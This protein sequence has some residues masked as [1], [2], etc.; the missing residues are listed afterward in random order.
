MGT[1]GKGKNVIS[2][3]RVKSNTGLKEKKELSRNERRSLGKIRASQALS[4]QSQK[5]SFIPINSSAFESTEES[6]LEDHIGQKAHLEQ[7]L[8]FKHAASTLNL[9]IITGL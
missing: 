5:P 1:T 2:P 3:C 4:C 7:S 6:G 8:S 9:I